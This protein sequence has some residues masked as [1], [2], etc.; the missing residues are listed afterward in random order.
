MAPLLRVDGLRTEFRTLRG[1]V[2]AVDG[3]SFEVEAGQMF[4]L[5]G[6]SGCGKS[7]TSQSIM[8]LYD[9]KKLARHSGKAILDGEDLL[10]VSQKRMR[11]IRGRDI[12]MIFQD[13]LSSLNPVFT[14]GWQIQEALKMHQKL[15][16]RESRER[17][18][19]MLRLTGIPSPDKRVDCYPHE[20]S[21]G[22]RQ[23]AM[24]AM[25]L[26]CTPKLLIADEPTTALDV[27]IQAQ[28]MEMIVDLKDRLN[29]GV[30]LITHD[31]G[32][33]AQT[34]SRVVVMYLGQVVEEGDS[35]DI[36]DNPRHPYTIGL[37]RSV[38]SVS[39]K[40][41]D[42][43]PV[44]QGSVPPLDKAGAGCRFADRCPLADEG[45]KIEPPAL[46]DLGGGQKARCRKLDLTGG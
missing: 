38:P 40:K 3:V 43:L 44:I 29:M 37:L 24:I 22:M 20:L 10:S 35:C 15:G 14:I 33:V 46:V 11:Q 1:S 39:T 8:R 13:A 42:P 7:V 41:G 45:C 28:I 32:V 5:V 19:E 21:G 34:C 6:E 9:E 31:L 36:F 26:V 12:S 23:R 18:I 16:K 25:A 4:G 27:T 30:L 17:A 2:T